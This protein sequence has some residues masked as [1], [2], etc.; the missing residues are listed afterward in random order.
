MYKPQP[1]IAATGK[2]K[3][4][5]LLLL[6]EIDPHGKLSKSLKTTYCMLCDL[7]VELQIL[8]YKS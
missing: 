1:I 8:G 3:E 5:I 7:E 2:A 6:S 4:E